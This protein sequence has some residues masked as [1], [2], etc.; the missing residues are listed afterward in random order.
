[1]RQ[2]LKGGHPIQDEHATPIGRARGLGFWEL[3]AWC[4]AEL[5]LRFF[6]AVSVRGASFCWALML[7]W[8]RSAPE[9][10]VLQDVRRMQTRR[11]WNGGGGGEVL[12]VGIV[13]RVDASQAEHRGAPGVHARPADRAT[14]AGMATSSTEHIGGL[15]WRYRRTRT[16]LCDAISGN[17]FTAVGQGVACSDG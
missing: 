12:T 14:V 3:R 16:D 8:N 4:A 17:D 2:R 11:D 15:R 5:G 9:R 10:P 7:V 6:A 1:M 13:G